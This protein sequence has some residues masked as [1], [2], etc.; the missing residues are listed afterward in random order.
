MYL[1]AAVN[2]ACTQYVENCPPP[3]EHLPFTGFN[4]VWF[5]VIAVAIIVI[6]VA[7]R[8]HL[9]NRNKDGDA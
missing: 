7:L 9:D 8:S 6:G 4:L 2:A 3:D 5:V 1:L